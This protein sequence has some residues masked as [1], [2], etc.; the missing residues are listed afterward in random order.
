MKA[1]L[2]VDENTCKGSALNIGGKVRVKEKL[3]RKVIIVHENNMVQYFFIVNGSLLHNSKKRDENHT[4]YTIPS[5]QMV[6]AESVCSKLSEVCNLQNCTVATFIH[7]FCFQNFH[8][9][10]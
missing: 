7:T 8:F 4:V 3:A 6:V 2:K 1:R 5:Y 9:R 10:W